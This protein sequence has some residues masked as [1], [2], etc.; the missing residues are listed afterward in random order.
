MSTPSNTPPLD[1]PLSTLSPP[2][3]WWAWGIL[4]LLALVWGSS[5]ILMK[6][7]LEVFSPI[8]IGALRIAIAFLVLLPFAL[9]H[10]KGI[11]KDK[12]KWLLLPGLIGNTIPAFLFPLAQTH[13]MSSVTGVLN[14]LTP[15]TTI[16]IGALLFQ[17]R[18]P[19]KKLLGLV[20]GFAGAVLLSTAKAEGGFGSINA[21]AFYVVL[22]TICY[23][24]SVNVIKYRLQDLAPVQIAA[25][26]FMMVGPPIL[27]FL[28]VGTPFLSHFTATDPIAQE[29]VWWALGYIIIL[30]MFG[31]AWALILFNRLIQ[32]TDA[33]FASTVTYLIPIVAVLWGVWDGESLVSGHYYGMGLILLGVIITNRFS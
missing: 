23:G 11:P 6:R 22:A 16:I 28:L 29:A 21:Y 15:L 25:I 20:I 30:A 10:L 1:A 14:G 33:I 3:R 2:N 9:R 26:A 13:L 17:Q 5:F 4:I 32:Y 31:T 19:S 12:W 7:G 24:T 18:I 8:E 27:L